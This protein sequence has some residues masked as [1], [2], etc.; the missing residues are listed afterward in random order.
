MLMFHDL[1]DPD[2]SVKPLEQEFPES[3]ELLL[4]ARDQI[5][6]RNLLTHPELRAHLFIHNDG[7][8]SFKQHGFKRRNS[9]IKIEPTK[10]GRNEPCYCGSQ[11]KY[12]NCCGSLV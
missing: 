8:L 7:G 10:L 2:Y 3:G 4:Q 5:R 9:W 1:V 12:K 11:K 6:G